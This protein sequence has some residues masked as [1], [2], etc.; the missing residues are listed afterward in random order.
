MAKN[1][2]NGQSPTLF[3]FQ[4][5]V[6]LAIHKN[7][8]GISL[9]SLVAKTLNKMILNRIKPEVEKILRREQNGFR[10][11]R[12]TTQHILALRRIIEGIKSRNMPA[13]LTFIDFKKAFDSSPRSPKNCD[14]D[15]IILEFCNNSLLNGEKPDQ[16]S[17]SNIIP[18]PKKGDLSDPQKL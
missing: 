10:P 14:L 8:R 2:I 7:Y 16:W 12:N 15:H 9:S 4:K 11:S 18:I 3:R 17:V 1:Q 5:K 13:V 6:T